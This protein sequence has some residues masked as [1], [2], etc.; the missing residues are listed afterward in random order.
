MVAL[1][2]PQTVLT[3]TAAANDLQQHGL[4]ALGLTIPNLSPAWAASAPGAYDPAALSLQLTGVRAPFRAIRRFLTTNTEFAGPDGKPLAGPI[5]ALQLHPEAARRLTRLVENR[6]GATPAIHPVPVAMAI[7]GITPPATLPVP[8]W[9]FCGD[10]IDTPGAVTIT[11]HDNRGLP[12]C[13]IYVAA[14][15]ADLLTALPGLYVANGAAQAVGDPGGLTAIAALASGVRAHVI[16]PHGWGYTATRDIAKLKVTDG[17]NAQAAV[18]AD[19]GLVDLAA[20][21]GLGRS[22]ADDTAD[23]TSKPLRW[24]WATSG[25]LARTR[26]VPPSVT[27]SRQ[28]LRVMAVDLDW[29]LLGNRS[30]G[31]LAGIPADDDTVPDF[32]LPAVRDPVPN[33]AYLLDA[34]DVLGAA[35]AILPPLVGAA[36]SF[37]A[38]ASPVLDEALAG[39][40][41]PGPPGHWPAFPPFAAPQP[42]G[43]ATNPR[44]GLTA[45]RRQAADG[46]G[47]DQDVIVTIPAGGVPDGAHLRVFPRRFQQIDA[48]GNVPSFIRPDG[49]AAIA[50]PGQPTK[51]LLVNAFGLGQGDNF[52]SP[53]NL[54][55]D[56]VV[57][58][59]TG[60]RR[61]FSQITV[62]VTGSESAAGLANSFAGTSLLATPALK[63]VLDGLGMRGIAGSPLFGIPRTT[64]LPS[65]GTAPLAFVRALASETQ[66]RQGPRLPT[67][68]R[69]DTVLAVG[70]AAAANTPL[71]WSAILSGARLS[72]E[73]RSA[74]PDLANPGN[75]AGPDI[76]A[77]GIHC[78]GFLARDLALHAVKRAQPIIPL[79]GGI[80][81]WVVATGGSNWNAPAADTTGTVAA[82]ML[83]TVA[84]VCDS[85]ELSLLPD[86]QQG[87]SVQGLVDA[88]A[89][90]LGVGTVPVNLANANEIVRRVQR[91]ITTAKHG[92]RDALWALRRA[93]GQARE[94]IYIETPGLARTARPGASPAAHEIDLI[95]VIRAQLVANPGLKVVICTPRLPDFDASRAGWGRRAFLQRKEALLDLTAA[96]QSRVAAFHPIGFPGRASPLR[97]TTIMVDDVWCLAGT[98]HLRRRGMT[99]DGAADV[100]SI[101]RQM[102]RGY[103]ASIARFRQA[104]MA[105]R[106]GVDAPATPAAATALWVRLAEPASA[107]GVCA[108]LLAEGGAGRLTPVWAGP[109][110]NAVLPQTDDVADPDGAAGAS[111]A[112]FIAAAVSGE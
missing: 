93:F 52:P 6:L 54:A 86:P 29:H 103:S 69:F 19:G 90:A 16:D 98:S 15:F 59:R 49:G 79:G 24:G 31:A 105:A 38:V 3:P 81:G 20:G 108:E 80:S 11:F 26:L 107:F 76:L 53:A 84:A 65:I 4:D 74:R 22:A 70:T 41:Q 72:G 30:A 91:E 8:E 27:L 55:L 51:I 82:A 33:F 34:Q 92:Q 109:A 28:F 60:K 12:V 77:T 32:L 73:A 47:A 88:A 13:P 67:M 85:P 46:A 78:E 50:Q 5:A 66:P 64:A 18:V 106:L 94:L 104:L 42:I 44:T 36:S 63:A 102:R 89:G 112:T 43:P 23:G 110:D 71:A 21:Q 87:D 48:I 99:F 9:F 45:A 58:D 56:M 96:A 17:S 40:A 39:P 25:T 57:T 75:P 83:E 62:T 95:D 1:I 68:M 37:A 111:F 61:I 2:P 97:T 101:D 14:L 7:S 100:A 10:T 35:A